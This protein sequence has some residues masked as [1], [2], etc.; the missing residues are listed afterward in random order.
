M[1]SSPRPFL[2][3]TLFRAAAG[4]LAQMFTVQLSSRRRTQ[5]LPSPVC[6]TSDGRSTFVSVVRGCDNVCSSCVVPFTRWRSD[7]GTSTQS[8][9][10]A[11]AS[12][13]RA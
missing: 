7:R 4:S 10:S 6:A 11:A 9:R 1:N 5:T 12:P 8:W 13:A 3:P 2:T